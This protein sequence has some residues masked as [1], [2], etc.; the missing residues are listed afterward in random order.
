MNS[1]YAL[2]LAVVLGVIAAF[3]VQDYIGKE[4]QKSLDQV[5]P[6]QVV[7][8]KDDIP[9]GTQLR[10][11]ILESKDWPAGYLTGQLTAWSEVEKLVGK[12][13]AQ[14]IPGGNPV[15]LDAVQTKPLAPPTA[16]LER[17]SRAFTIST[18]L[19]SGV[20]GM[21]KPGSR[22]D[23]LAHVR[24]LEPSGGGRRGTPS[25]QGA[26]TSTVTLL[27]NLKVL[28]VGAYGGRHWGARGREETDASSVTVSVTPI[29]AGLLAYGQKQ[30]PLTL[31]LR[32]EG[33]LEQV[34]PPVVD[35]RTLL[36]M[37][38]QARSGGASGR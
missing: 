18:D 26:G 10:E 35:S 16:A 31:I 6:V 8:S 4:R 5:K 32:G 20:A 19:I 37:M 22:V 17:G 30:G 24:D 1:K 27:E 12:V 29:Q 38:Q 33:D 7:F 11:E 2:V 14:R 23:V 25:T 28:G 36:Q 3:A 34:Q 15:F 21:I 9:A 13:A